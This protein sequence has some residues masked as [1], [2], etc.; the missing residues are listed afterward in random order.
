MNPCPKCG[1]PIDPEAGNCQQCETGLSQQSEAVSISTEAMVSDH[2]CLN[3]GA[4]V[5]ASAKVCH[6]CASPINSEAAYTNTLTATIY[7]NRR[8]I[9]R[10][11]V[12]FSALIVVGVMAL[13]Y[14]NSGPTKGKAVRTL[15]D[16][17]AAN[18]ARDFDRVRELLQLPA[19]VDWEKSRSDFADKGMVDGITLNARGIEILAEKGKW[20]GLM[21]V[22]TDA[23]ASEFADKV[24]V[25]ADD[26]YA[27]RTYNPTAYAV[28]YWNGERFEILGLLNIGLLDLME[29]R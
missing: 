2:V 19:S 15:R 13:I 9:V 16:F 10:G 14:L 4:T 27:L 7:R 24:K 22:F 26:C 5:E 6:N 28:F 12:L 17:M 3:C 21:K 11:S 8:L 23:S 29:V 25:S 20:G 1:S 18:D